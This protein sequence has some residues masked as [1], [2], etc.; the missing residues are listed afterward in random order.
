MLI[1]HFNPISSLQISARKKY[2]LSLRD[3][4]CTTSYKVT[5][6]HVRQPKLNVQVLKL[7]NDNKDTVL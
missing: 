3:M 6:N 4:N 5:C 1:F 2:L 7:S